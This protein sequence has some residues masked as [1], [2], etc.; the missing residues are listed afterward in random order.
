MNTQPNTFT[1]NLMG[2]MNNCCYRVKVH[3]RQVPGAPPPGWHRVP[4]RLPA[5]CRLPPAACTGW[6]VP[7]V[8]P[9]LR[10]PAAPALTLPA[11]GGFGLQFEHP[12]VAA[13]TPGGWMNRADGSSAVAAVG[14]PAKAA[15]AGSGPPTPGGGSTRLFTMEEVRVD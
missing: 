9:G 5:A 15:K 13:G 1:W 4:A 14:P 7:P 2:M 10:S 6:L 12:T 8:S 3:P 11:G